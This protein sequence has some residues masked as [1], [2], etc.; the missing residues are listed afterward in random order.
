MQGSIELEHLHR[1]RFAGQLVTDKVV[2]DIA[3]GEGYGSA[4]LAKFA[5]RVLGVDIANDAV[6]HANQK[7]SQDNLEYLVGS[8]SAIPLEDHSVSAKR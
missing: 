2:L 3:S 1:Y 5:R 8:C 6:D 4:Y 7:Y